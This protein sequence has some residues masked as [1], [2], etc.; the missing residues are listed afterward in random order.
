MNT[1]PIFG[2]LLVAALLAPPV[3]RAD[4]PVNVQN[5]VS[6]LLGYMTASACE[7]YRNGD[8]YDS[9]RA[10]AHMR[11]KYRYL[12]DRNLIATTEQFIDRAASTSSV[13]GNPY[14]IRCGGGAAIASHRW[15]TE[16]LVEL[17]AAQ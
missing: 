9:R 4:A 2:S 11:E 13:S 7:F 12:N 5:E 1:R 15:L 3:A 8:W 14:Q 10:A 16:K 6:F 17:R